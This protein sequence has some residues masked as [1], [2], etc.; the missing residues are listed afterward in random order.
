MSD[1]QEE[2][3]LSPGPV[4]GPCVYWYRTRG[5]SP[6]IQFIRTSPRQ[7]RRW[8]FPLRPPKTGHKRRVQFGKRKLGGINAVCVHNQQ[9]FPF[10][11]T[12]RRSRVYEPLIISPIKIAGPQS[13]PR[14]TVR[15][16]FVLGLILI[17]PLLLHTPKSQGEPT[18][19][20][21]MERGTEFEADEAYL[22][23]SKFR[24]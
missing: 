18:K 14:L 6:L 1:A 5:G 22:E 2:D 8:S 10:R 11:I 23:V 3:K 20:V 16:V 7:S 24:N 15:D 9:P 12:R 4:S 19:Q 17:C 21:R 13:C